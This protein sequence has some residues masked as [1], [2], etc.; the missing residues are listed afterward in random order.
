[1]KDIILIH[2]RYIDIDYLQ[3]SIKAV[4]VPIGGIC[5]GVAGFICLSIRSR[6]EIEGT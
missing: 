2:E 3:R 4:A 5:P 6:K 1:M